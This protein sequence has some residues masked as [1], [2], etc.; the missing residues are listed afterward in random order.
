[1]P[2]SHGKPQ[3][4]TFERLADLSIG[5]TATVELCRLTAGPRT[6]DLVAVKRLHH[7]FAD[8][9]ELRD[10]FRDEAWMAS[11]LRHP[12]VAQVVGWGRDEG[13]YYIAFEFVR[14]V[15]LAR[16]MRSVFKTGEAFTERMVV[17]LGSCLCDALTA[18]HELR[19]QDGTPLNLV[20]RDLTPGNVL[21]SFD[22]ELKITDF[23]LAWANQRTT[24]TVTGILRGEPTCMAPEQIRAEPIDGRADIFGLGVLLFELFSG[25]P[26]WVATTAVEM[27]RCILR[28][29]APD[30]QAVC[31]KLDGALCE[32][33][34]HCLEKDP[35]ARY[36][37]ARELGRRFEHWLHA[38]GYHDNRP[39]LA[40]FVRRNS[41]RQ[42]RW[43]DRA[44]AGELVDGG[45]PP[46]GFEASRDPAPEVT[47]IT[48]G[49]A[50]GVTTPRSA[51]A[52][53]DDPTDGDARLAETRALP[54]ARL[55]QAAEAAAAS[56]AAADDHQTEPLLRQ[57][58]RH[59]DAAGAPAPPATPASHLP[60]PQ[61]PAPPPIPGAPRPVGPGSLVPQVVAPP[62]VPSPSP[63]S[64]AP[65]GPPV[66]VAPPA[67]VATGAR[68]PA[69]IPPATRPAR[70]SQMPSRA[71]TPVQESDTESIS[72]VIEDPTSMTAT[73]PR[74]DGA[75]AAER[76]AIE[77]LA[78][79]AGAVER[80]RDDARTKA[81][82]ARQAAVE[83]QAAG[84]TAR[85][86]AERA[87]K[88]GEA[89]ALA[90]EAA[91]HAASAVDEAEI[92]ATLVLEALEAAATGDFPRALGALQ[93]AEEAMP[94]R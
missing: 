64:A 28:E 8:D 33:V 46:P 79:L 2:A 23:G 3:Q 83:A 67:H 11:A 47:P 73:K 21:C 22:G 32:V 91:A 55:V 85:H 86:A 89:A 62:L 90:G 66:V 34:G 92:A 80:V 93:R 4:L 50:A 63:A 5:T 39:A 65:H 78:A 72:I 30:L 14:G 9:P 15:S 70:R 69:P 1:M 87:Q 49:T 75:P 26:P 60:L 57:Q 84:L 77:R 59:A 18:A 19:T 51:D 13:G 37:S 27:M 16:L 40:R 29:P 43:I 38:H 10:L 35:A 74:I 58:A 68:A 71:S 53:E 31:P 44:I 88:A 56:P 25:R 48:G 94:G 24:K 45:E 76:A 17:H 36:Q 54:T 6:G 20:H 42:M 81:D 7:D 82:A 41:M 52:L 12:N 61:I